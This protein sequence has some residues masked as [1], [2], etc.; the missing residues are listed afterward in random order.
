V[1]GIREGGLLPAARGTCREYT[2]M[3]PS[4][5]NRG[6][7]RIVAVGRAEFHYTKD[8]YRSFRRINE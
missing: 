4:R 7:R 5:K 2:V 1:F 6:A 3:T 8:R